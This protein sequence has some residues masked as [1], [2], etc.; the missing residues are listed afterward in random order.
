M[1]KSP[2]SDMWWATPVVDESKLLNLY[3]E[4]KHIPFAEGIRKT[5]SWYMENKEDADRRP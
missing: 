2:E 1:R 4:H 3:P 5:I